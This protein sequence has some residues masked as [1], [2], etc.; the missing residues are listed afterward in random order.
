MQEGQQRAAISHT[1]VCMRTAVA[2]FDSVLG[3]VCVCLPLYVRPSLHVSCSRGARACGIHSTGVC[4]SCECCKEACKPV[5]GA[6]LC[7]VVGLFLSYISRVVPGLLALLCVC[8]C[9]WA[10]CT[11][12]SGVWSDALWRQQEQ[13]REGHMQ[14]AT[15]LLLRGQG[16]LLKQAGGW[17][18]VCMDAATHLRP[19]ASG[20]VS[21][22]TVRVCT[23][24]TLQEMESVSGL[25]AVTGVFPRC[26]SCAGRAQ[27]KQGLRGR[28]V[29]VPQ[30][31]AHGLWVVSVA[32]ASSVAE[33]FHQSVDT[34]SPVRLWACSSSSKQHA[35]S[36]LDAAEVVAAT[37]LYSAHLC[38]CAPS[39]F[40]LR[41]GGHFRGAHLIGWPRILPGSA[42]FR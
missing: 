25:L 33:G 1:T 7:F 41:A 16:L 18:H 24:S 8:S 30:Q 5:S 10:L 40:R 15:R 4:V 9:L 35:F 31:P 22:C 37:F 32:H 27:G 29:P 13:L 19:P 6:R 36:A 20:G 38:P 28:D 21:S 12:S 34:F 2:A 39:G 42:G 3:C 11:S 26:L 23:V 14:H 17:L